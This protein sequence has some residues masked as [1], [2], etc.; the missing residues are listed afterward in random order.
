[1]KLVLT[2]AEDAEIWTAVF[3]LVA[4][5]KPVPQ[6]TTPPPVSA[7]IYILVSADALVVQ[8]GQLR[9]RIR[10]QKAGR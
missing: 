2:K 1:M 10:A 5:T 7:I 3:D 9:R 4:R 6:S 8:H